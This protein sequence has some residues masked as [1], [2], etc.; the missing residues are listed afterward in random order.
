LSLST[1]LT[2]EPLQMDVLIIKKE[3]DIDIKKNIAAIFQRS[4]KTYG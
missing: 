1:K 4:M 2:A 3:K